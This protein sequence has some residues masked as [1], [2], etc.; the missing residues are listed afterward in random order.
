MACAN[1][2]S[3]EVVKVLLDNEA[4]VKAKAQVCVTSVYAWF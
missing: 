1:G 4:E 3:V 2:A